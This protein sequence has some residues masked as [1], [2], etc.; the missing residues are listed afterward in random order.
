MKTIE[1]ILTQIEL[2]ITQNKYEPVETD[3]IELKDLSGGVSAELYKSTCAFL[4]AEGGMIII[5]IH[6]DAS[7]K[8]YVLKG[9]NPEIENALKELSKKFTREDNSPVDLSNSFP[10]YEIKE[11]MD[12]RVCIVYI[13]KLDEEQKYVF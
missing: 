1:K 11:F 10:T 6:E 4:N 9:Y 8:K 13:E 3:K 12:S 5:G 2:C 7:N